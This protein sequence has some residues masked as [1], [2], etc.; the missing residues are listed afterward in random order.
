MTPDKDFPDEFVKDFLISM[1]RYKNIQDGL[2]TSW[3]QFKSSRLSNGVEKESKYVAES[4]GKDRMD[5]HKSPNAEWPEVLSLMIEDLSSQK[6]VGVDWEIV[7]YDYIG[8][9][10][11]KSII[12]VRRLPD[13]EVFSIGDKVTGF[14]DNRT[15]TKFKINSDGQLLTILDGINT[16]S[17][18]DGMK[19]LKK[20]GKQVPPKVYYEIDTSTWDIIKT[21]FLHFPHYFDSEEKA[22]DYVLLNRPILSVNDVNNMCGDGGCVGAGWL[23][24]KLKEVAKS[25]INP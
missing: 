12:S 15:I 8:E 25:K 9:D 21:E 19:S 24:D 16:L 1:N 22:N 18:K 4:I 20:P 11:N 13:G 10:S 23:T 5:I 6:N 2:L 7:K 14:F 3:E 17:E